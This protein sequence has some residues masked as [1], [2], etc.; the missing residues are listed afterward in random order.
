MTSQRGMLKSI[1]S[2]VNTLASILYMGAE[3][4]LLLPQ[5]SMLTCCFFMKEWLLVK[6][7]E[8]EP[9][10]PLSNA[11]MSLNIEKVLI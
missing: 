9:Y 3:G 2:R 11:T 8:D 4:F 5:K 10:I 1:Q 6:I 7:H